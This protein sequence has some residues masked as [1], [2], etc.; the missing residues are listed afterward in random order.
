MKRVLVFGTF[1]G[2]HPGHEDFFRQAKSKGDFLIVVV[3]RDVNVKKIKGKL[4]KIEEKKRLAEV[5]KIEYVDQ[6][7]LGDKKDKYK[8]I[9]KLKPDVICLGYDQEV[10]LEGLK[11]KLQE[12]GL[13][14]KI[15]TLKSYKSSLYKS[16][17]LKI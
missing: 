12:F 15:Y 14:A 5:K 3:A 8:I 17:K 13:S 6:A 2:I 11:R 7:V 9:K 1:D 4:P 16:S 10:D